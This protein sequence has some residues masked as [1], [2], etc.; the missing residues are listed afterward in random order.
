MDRELSIALKE[1]RQRISQVDPL[2]ARLVNLAHGS[3]PIQYGVS[4]RIGAATIS[5]I[6]APGS[7]TG[8]LLDRQ[9]LRFVQIMHALS[10][11]AGIDDGSWSEIEDLVREAKTF[12][13][14]ANHEVDANSRLLSYVSNAKL[15][16]LPNIADLPDELIDDAVAA[17][18]PPKAFTLTN[19]TI[20]KDN[21][22]QE[23]L[24]TIRISL[25]RVEAWW[26]FDLAIPD[27]AQDTFAQIQQ[28]D[29]NQTVR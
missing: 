28:K 4:V 29:D 27:G 14:T 9:T 2:L 17:W 24:G 6:P 26:T 5:G 19:A 15:E 13:E 3:I 16:R 21:G 1:I 7:V 18:A 12:L 11:T 23:N 22:T 10:V 20:V 8:E 25:A